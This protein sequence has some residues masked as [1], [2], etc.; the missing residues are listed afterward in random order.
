MISDRERI[1]ELEEENRQLRALLQLDDTTAYDG[2]RLTAQ[3]RVVLAALCRGT[4]V[5][6]ISYLLDCLDRAGRRGTAHARDHLG[7]VVH[8]LR[9]KLEPHGIHIRTEWGVGLSIPLEDKA[10]LHARRRGA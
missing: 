1:E 6:P 4:G 7:V 10:V 9:R 3:Q 8:R 2:L 5:L